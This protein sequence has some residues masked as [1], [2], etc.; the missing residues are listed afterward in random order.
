MVMKE[1]YLWAMGCTPKFIQEQV[2]CSKNQVTQ[3]NVYWREVIT[4]CN[5]ESPKL[6]GTVEADETALGQRK[7]NRGKRQRQDGPIWY[8][9]AVEYDEYARCGARKA[10]SAKKFTPF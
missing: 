2:P 5:D 10:K 1:M 6:A 9:T 4:R 8:Q 3:L 7:Y